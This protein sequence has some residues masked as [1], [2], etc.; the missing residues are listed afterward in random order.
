MKPLAISA[1]YAPIPIC[2]GEGDGAGMRMA[3]YYQ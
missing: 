3:F 2:E 1:R